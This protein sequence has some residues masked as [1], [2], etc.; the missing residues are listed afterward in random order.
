LRNLNLVVAVDLQNETID[1]AT[2]GPWG[3]PHDPDPLPDGTILI[4]DNCFAQGAAHGSRVLRFDPRQTTVVWQYGGRQTAPLRSDIRSCQQLLA[5]GNVLITESDCGRLIEVTPAGEIVWEYIHPARGGASNELIP[6]VNGA[7]RYD[8][9]ELPFV[10]AKSNR[11][12][13]AGLDQSN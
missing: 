7:R 5:N 13:T 9:R 12:S 6:I 10:E 11:P 8:V 1:W 2:S 4:F 3:L